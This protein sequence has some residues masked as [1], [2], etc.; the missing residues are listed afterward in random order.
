MSEEL[1]ESAEGRGMGEGNSILFRGVRM[2]GEGGGWEEKGGKNL[3]SLLT[4]NVVVFGQGSSFHGCVGQV[5]CLT[6]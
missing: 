1:S 2:G 4:R 6:P 3:V 5:E